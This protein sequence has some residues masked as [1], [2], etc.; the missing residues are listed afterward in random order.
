M[1][2][3]NMVNLG[4]ITKIIVKHGTLGTILHNHGILGKILVRFQAPSGTFV[5]VHMASYYKA[6]TEV[7]RAFTGGKSPQ[8]VFSRRFY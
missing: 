5:R 1:L 7:A 4:I 8:A 6:L 2:V 3:K